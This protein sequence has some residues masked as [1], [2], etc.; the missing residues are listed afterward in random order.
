MAETEKLKMMEQQDIEIVRG[1]TNTFSIFVTNGEKDENGEY[2]PYIL[3]AGETLI[4]G[5][6]KDPRELTP[7]IKKTV[8]VGEG[9][10]YTVEFTPDDTADLP[11]GKYFYDVSVKSGADYFN[12]IPTSVFDIKKNVTKWGDVG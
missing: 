4:F 11:F 5:I 12:V 1:T 8:A 9:G 7:L 2:V 10:V 3:Q 6:K